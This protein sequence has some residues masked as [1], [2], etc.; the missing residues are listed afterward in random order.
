MILALACLQKIRLFTASSLLMA[1]S[2]VAPTP[3]GVSEVG[4]RESARTCEGF[5]CLFL[6]EAASLSGGDGDRFKQEALVIQGPV[7][8]NVA[9][10]VPPTCSDTD[11]D[12]TN[13]CGP[14]DTGDAGTRLSV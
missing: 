10:Y 3:L 14:G 8:W 6:G 2:F 12:Q 5:S 1:T 11:A 4:V 7:H 9:G 13:N